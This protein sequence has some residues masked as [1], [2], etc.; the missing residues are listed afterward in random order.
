MRGGVDKVSGGGDGADTINAADG[1]QDII[2]C[3]N[4]ANDVANV[5]AAD[6][7]DGDCETI[8]VVV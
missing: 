6:F 5:D 3:G 7:V 8:N 1:E 2:E 4:G